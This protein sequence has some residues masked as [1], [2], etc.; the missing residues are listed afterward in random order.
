LVS[1]RFRRIGI[2]FLILIL[3]LTACSR[4]ESLSSIKADII[5]LDIS[6]SSTNSV[7]SFS[8]EDH[9]PSSLSQRKLQLEA[10]IRSALDDRTAVYF[11]FV[12]K[13]YGNTDI[14]T[15]VNSSLI[16][17]I[18]KVLKEDILNEKLLQ[19]A[20]SAI[21]KAWSEALGMEIKD[22]NSCLTGKVESVIIEGSNAAI[23]EKNSNSIASKLCAAAS[24]SVY[25]FNQLQGDPENI[26]SDI[27]GAVD[28]SLQKLASDE[29]R[30]LTSDGRQLVFIPR[31]I[32]VSDLIQVSSGK[33]ITSTVNALKDNAAACKLAQSEASTFTPTYQGEVEIISDGF[34]GSKTDIKNADREKLR[35]Y[36]IC[37]FGTRQITPIDIGAKGIDLGAL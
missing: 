15:L 17:Q 24:N 18:D 9:S 33:T 20:R 16:L 7:G 11:G 23:S 5:L 22:S 35:E 30:L 27:Q 34:A 2:C 4:K 13:T 28:R 29:R 19:E 21:S 37:W 32:L 36:W 31:I 25:Q 8:S 6:G 1:R 10:K 3:P 26:G 12:R 14:V